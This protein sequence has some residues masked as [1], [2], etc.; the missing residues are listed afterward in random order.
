MSLPLLAN[1]RGVHGETVGGTRFFGDITIPALREVYR[2]C[3]LGGRARRPRAC[4][5]RLGGYRLWRRGGEE[6]GRG[7]SCEGGCGG[8]GRIPPARAHLSIRFR[9]VHPSPGVSADF[10]LDLSPPH[11]SLLTARVR[12]TRRHS[13]QFAVVYGRLCAA[14]FASVLLLLQ[15]LYIYNLFPHRAP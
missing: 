13:H 1:S 4:S 15:W 14:L 3:H 5:W 12:P 9:H 8:R 6:A 10:H 2:G 7:G 11:S